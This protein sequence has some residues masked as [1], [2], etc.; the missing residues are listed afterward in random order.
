[1]NIDIDYYQTP[2]GELI[3]GSYNNALCLCDWRYRKSRP[4]IDRRLSKNLKAKLIERKSDTTE[5]CKTQLDEYFSQN[6]KHFTLPVLL[7]GTEFQKSV[8]NALSKID[9]GSKHSY[10]QLASKLNRK[11]AVRAVANANG[12]N[13]ISIIIPCHRIIGSDGSL[14]GYA[15][16][17]DVKRK[18]LALEQ[19]SS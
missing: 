14:T 18:L 10:L 15:G 13:A 5:L 11:S 19:P 7:V 3:L 1:M 9:Y 8:W 12:A 4:S 17:V 16:G 6:R 2:Y